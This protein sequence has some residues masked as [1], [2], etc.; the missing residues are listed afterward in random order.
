[1][2]RLNVLPPDTVTRASEYISEIV[3]FIEGIVAKGFAYASNGSVYFDTQ[4]FSQSGE[5]QYLKLLDVDNMQ[6]SI[7]HGMVGTILSLSYVLTVKR[8]C[9]GLSWREEVPVR[10]RT[11]ES[12]EGRRALLGISVGYRP[13]WLAYR[14]LRHGKRDLRREDAHSFRWN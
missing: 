11:M 5:H 10:L 8:G 2:A 14:M 3:D 1:M 6:S 13:P 12:S 7:L 4:A 9:K